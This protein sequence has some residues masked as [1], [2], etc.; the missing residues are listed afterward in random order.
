MDTV[1]LVS[2]LTSKDSKTLK[3]MHSLKKKKV[4]QEKGEYLTEGL[5]AV[6]DMMKEGYV[7]Y[8]AIKVS[9]YVEYH[10]FLDLAK[11]LDTPVYVLDDELFANLEDTVN[12]Q[13]LVAVVSKKVVQLRDFKAAPDIYLLLDSIQDPGNMGAIIRTAVG[14]GVK[15]I[16]LMKGCVDV[17]NDKTVRST[18]SAITKVPLYENVTLEDIM[19]LKN[20]HNLHFYGTA[21]EEAKPY[22]DVSYAKP[23]VL[24]VG[25]EANGI[26]KEVLNLCD[27][28]IKIPLYGD[29]ESLNVSIAT[30]LCLYK[31]RELVEA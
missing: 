31:I 6:T 25:N 22:T 20:T 27:E 19:D 3:Y 14:A 24:V 10:D 8:A 30:A 2:R 1:D 13:G 16:F 7:R 26:S 11:Y 9:K 21:L 18:M 28:R 4:R 12:G 5:R 15:G 23:T 17:Y 29:I